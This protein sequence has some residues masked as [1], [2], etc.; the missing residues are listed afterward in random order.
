MCVCYTARNLQQFQPTCTDIIFQ[1]T[2]LRDKGGQV[3]EDVTDLSVH[4]VLTVV[5]LQTY[6]QLLTIVLDSRR[7]SVTTAMIRPEVQYRLPSGTVPR[8]SAHAAITNTL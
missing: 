4:L 5:L 6:R 3:G 1:Y 8:H 2:L 7:I